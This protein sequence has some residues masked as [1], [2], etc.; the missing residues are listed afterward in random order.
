MRPDF[1]S[2][3]NHRFTLSAF[4]VNGLGNPHS[5][6]SI[7]H[8]GSGTR[9]PPS[10][11]RSLTSECSAVSSSAVLRGEFSIVEREQN[12]NGSSRACMGVGETR[13]YFRLP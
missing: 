12:H 7:I 3:Q 2:N 4:G 6:V 5:A 10:V 11:G 8:N 13:Q 9:D 1:S